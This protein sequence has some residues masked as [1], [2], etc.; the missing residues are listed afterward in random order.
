[1]LCRQMLSPRPEPPLI[2]ITPGVLR[3]IDNTPHT[4]PL[5]VV[6]YPRNDMANLQKLAE[7]PVTNR[8]KSPGLTEV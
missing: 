8:W 1:M 7:L 2:E 3:W 4:A 6:S 5:D